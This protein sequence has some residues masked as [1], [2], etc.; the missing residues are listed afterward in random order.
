MTTVIESNVCVACK[1]ANLIEEIK[2]ARCLECSKLYCI[3]FAST[4]DPHKCVECLSEITLTKETV[5]KEYTSYNEETDVVT[6]YRRR[7]KSIRLEGMDWLFAQ[8]KI[9][10]MS[11]DALELAIEYHRA[12]LGGLLKER[13]DRRTKWLHR[14]A[15]APLPKATEA[16][17]IDGTSS[18][19][20]VKTTKSI[21]STKTAATASSILQSLLASG[22]SID[23]IMKIMAAAGAIKK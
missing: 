13:E 14:Y 8:R 10:S 7:A 19:T 1:E 23:E 11:D 21:K 12:L 22:K 5:S 3:H 16:L 4:I 6:T 9:H 18:T 17:S 2:V 20:V 15:G